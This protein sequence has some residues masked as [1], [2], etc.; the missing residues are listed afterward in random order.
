[1]LYRLERYGREWVCLYV[2]TY[3]S[4]LVL[5][6]IH[7]IYYGYITLFICEVGVLV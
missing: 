3:E 4:S 1:M 6:V 5:I 2:K 7:F